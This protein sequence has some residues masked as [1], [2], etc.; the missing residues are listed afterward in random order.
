MACILVIV[1]FDKSDMTIILIKLEV[2]KNFISSA[3]DY[4]VQPCSLSVNQSEESMNEMNENACSDHP[5]NINPESQ[6]IGYFKD[7]EILDQI[8]KDVR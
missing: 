5:L 1:Y 3:D 4:I 6:W 2:I 7:N 8:D